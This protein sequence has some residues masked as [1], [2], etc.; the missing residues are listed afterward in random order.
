MEKGGRNESM[1]GE[2]SRD[3]VEMTGNMGKKKRGK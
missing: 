1:R 3:R 2:K